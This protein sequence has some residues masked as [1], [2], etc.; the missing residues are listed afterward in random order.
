MSISESFQ[1]NWKNTNEDD[2]KDEI[3]N[4]LNKIREAKGLRKKDDKLKQ[5][6]QIVSDLNKGYTAVE[7]DC[8]SK[9]EFLR[10]VVEKI[11][12]NDINPT[13]GLN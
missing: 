2:A 12:A 4:L 1:E 5:A 6:K 7:N 13:S 8:K 10:D 9:I 3:Y 11:K